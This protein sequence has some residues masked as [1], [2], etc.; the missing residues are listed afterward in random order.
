MVRIGLKTRNGLLFPTILRGMKEPFSE[1]LSEGGKTNS[2]GRANEVIEI[3]LQDKSRLNE[4]YDCMFEEDAWARMRAADAIEK[5][6]RVH[7]EWLEPYIDKFLDEL[8]DST[9]PS[10]QWHLAEIF[11]AVNLTE[12]QK[13]RAIKWLNDLLST[14]DVD[15]IA[16][17]N[18]M[19]TLVQFTKDGSFPRA[20][21]ISLLKIQQKHKSNA[22]IR[23][24]TKLLEEFK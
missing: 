11:G 20:Q 19:K 3:I 22:V 24:A 7:P 6:C 14:K 9:Q 15:W 2:L 1:M 16:S 12:A 4:L 18:S 17:A 13:K 8:A 21:M 5:I 10:I 23:R